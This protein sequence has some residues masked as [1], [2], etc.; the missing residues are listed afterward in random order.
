MASSKEATALLVQTQRHLSV[1]KV[2]LQAFVFSIIGSCSGV[3]GFMLT[4][5]SAVVW[6]LSCDNRIL[7]REKI[8]RAASCS[9]RSNGEAVHLSTV[10]MLAPQPSMALKGTLGGLTGH[11]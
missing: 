9:L 6:Q 11:Q 10:P 1:C 7:F 2:S 3:R 8:Q 4:M 5:S